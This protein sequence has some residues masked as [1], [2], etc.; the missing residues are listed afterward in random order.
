MQPLSLTV[1]VQQGHT[2]TGLGLSALSLIHGGDAFLCCRSTFW[3]AHSYAEAILLFFNVIQTLGQ[4][5]G[6]LH[7]EILL[8]LNMRFANTLVVEW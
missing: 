4:W 1:A 3:G 7:F 8:Y 6:P 2:V 5:T